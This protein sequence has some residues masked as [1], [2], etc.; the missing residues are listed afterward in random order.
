MTDLEQGLNKVLEEHQQLVRVGLR[1]ERARREKI[2][3]GV[4]DHVQRVQR[5]PGRLQEVLE[6]LAMAPDPADRAE[7]LL[8][9]ADRFRGSPAAL[10]C[11]DGE[12][13]RGCAKNFDR[14]DFGRA[15]ELRIYTLVGI[16]D[17]DGAGIAVE[18]ERRGLRFKRLH[19]GR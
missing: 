9:L 7:M 5:G 10:L 12:Y 3:H 11:L 18:Q 19:F 8:S 14:L 17:V 13:I 2:V 6:M 4:R 1:F 15:I 16:S